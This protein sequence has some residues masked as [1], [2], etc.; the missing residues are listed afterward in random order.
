MHTAY[1]SAGGTSLY[2]DGDDGTEYFYAHN[3]RNSVKTGQRVA[4]GDIVG[5]VGTSGNAP[6]NAPHVHF[7]R[8]PGGPA[9]NPYSFLRRIC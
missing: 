9:V 2:L 1:S 8:H 3:S 5:A 7:E 4:A 6:K